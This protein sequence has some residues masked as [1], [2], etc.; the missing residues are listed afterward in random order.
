MN[1]FL[2]DASFDS[3]I[4]G[5]YITFLAARIWFLHEQCVSPKYLSSTFTT[6]PTKRKVYLK[7]SSMQLSNNIVT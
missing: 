1:V 4:Q 3:Q 5:R 7:V 6:K 2:R